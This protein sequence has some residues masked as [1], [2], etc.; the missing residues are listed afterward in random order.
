MAPTASHPSI[1]YGCPVLSNDTWVKLLNMVPVG[2]TIRDETGECIYKNAKAT[3][4]F[5]GK[6]RKNKPKHM[7]VILS[8]GDY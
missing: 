8:T 6:R 1:G 4:Y 3:D 2:V 7:H 5:P